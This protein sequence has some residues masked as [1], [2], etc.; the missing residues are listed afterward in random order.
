VKKTKLAKKDQVKLLKSM[1]EVIEKFEEI[2]RLEESI[3][4][5]I[6]I[7]MKNNPDCY[8]M[9]CSDELTKT[10]KAIIK[11]NLYVTKEL[12]YGD[13]KISLHYENVNEVILLRVFNEYMD[14]LKGSYR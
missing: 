12:L 13:I 1:L 9:N 8:E 14:E 10:T 11:D 3:N 6:T 4:E 5:L 7:D 2:R